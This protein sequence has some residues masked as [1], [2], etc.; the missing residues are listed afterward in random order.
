MPGVV[1]LTQVCRVFWGA[2]QGPVLGLRVGSSEVM[3]LVSPI[4]IMVG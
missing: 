1:P 4:S 2:R 3:M